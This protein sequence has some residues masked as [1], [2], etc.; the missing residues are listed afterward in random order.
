MNLSTTGIDTE[1]IEE[2]QDPTFVILGIICGLVCCLTAVGYWDCKREATQ[3]MLNVKQVAENI[4]EQK[5]TEKRREYQQTE[6]ALETQPQND[7]YVDVHDANRQ[8]W[9]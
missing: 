2:R 8:K 4:I 9:I 5:D 6:I 1:W 3:S 7:V